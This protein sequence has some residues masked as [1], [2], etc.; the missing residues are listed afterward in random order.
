MLF[1]NYIREFL[2]NITLWG[3]LKMASKIIIIL[4]VMDTISEAYSFSKSIVWLK[5]Q[6]LNLTW[7]MSDIAEEHYRIEIVKTNI[8]DEPPSSYYS[9]D[10]S[11]T[12]DYEIELTNDYSYI[13]RVQTVNKYGTFSSFSDSTALLIYSENGA[14]K[15]ALSEDNLPEEFSLSQNFPNPFNSTTTIQYK[16]PQSTGSQNERVLLTIYNTLGQK[17]RTLVDENQQY[18]NYRVVW[19][20]RDDFGNNVA[21]GHYLFQIINGKYKASKKMILMK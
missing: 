15:A 5:E 19:D 8:L 21:S 12:N 14:A 4:V 3:T 10:Y 7:D 2:H 1:I 6:V 16:I 13:F 17:T 20:G 11:M 18:G 9:F